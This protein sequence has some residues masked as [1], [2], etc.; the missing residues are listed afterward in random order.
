MTGARFSTFDCGVVALKLVTMFVG[1]LAT[2]PTSSVQ[3]EGISIIDDRLD[4][5]AFDLFDFFGLLV[6]TKSIVLE[7]EQPMI[8]ILCAEREL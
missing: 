5:L 4:F 7:T 1:E 3:S 2:V 8:V 6:A